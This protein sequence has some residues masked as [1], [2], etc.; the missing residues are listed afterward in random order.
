ML[1][2]S[3]TG[4]SGSGGDFPIMDFAVVNLGRMEDTDP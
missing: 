2:S 4:G 1:S 3:V